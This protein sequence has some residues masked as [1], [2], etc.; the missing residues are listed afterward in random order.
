MYTDESD[1]H[2]ERQAPRLLMDLFSGFGSPVSAAAAELDLDRFEPVDLLSGPAIDVLDDD[3]FQL[4][5]R[6]CASGVVGAAVAAPPCA[7]FSRARLRPGGP[8]PVRT[9]RAF[10][11]LP[12]LDP[13]QQHELD[14]S[15]AM[16]ER[17]R[18]LLALVASR[19]G[20]VVL[21]N[22][23]SSLT[24]LSPRMTSWVSACAP[25]LTNV[26]ACT[27]GRDVY[28]AWLFASNVPD[29]VRIASDC[30]RPP[31]THPPL[32]GKRL[33]DGSFATRQTAQYPLTLAQALVSVLRPWVTSGS[34]LHQIRTWSEHLPLRIPW[35]INHQ[36]VED[37]AGTSSTACWTTP[38]GPDCFRS[39]RRAWVRRLFAGGLHLKIV[40]ALL[41]G[42][43][44]PPL[45]QDELTPF[46]Q[47]VRD[48]LQLS[49]DRLWQACLAVAPGQPFRLAL[50]RRLAGV[51]SRSSTAPPRGRVLL[52]PQRR[53]TSF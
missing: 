52:P 48:F 8:K 26:A 36:R 16:R 20:A 47:D 42:N 41:T 35:P 25:V 1:S 13:A 45:S 40:A 21:E 5:R 23:S 50:W 51:R 22:P 43:E 27:H 9:P 32:A 33:P 7:S 12:R 17:S 19:G 24:W 14:T 37:G 34:G 6:L 39:L 2:T 30:P 10:D 29:M 18:E 28:K 3:A 15:E 31:H 44:D 38:V 53:L 11:G 49:D 4:L 46:L